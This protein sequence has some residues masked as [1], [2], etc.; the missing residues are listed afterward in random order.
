MP[1]RNRDLLTPHVSRRMPIQFVASQQSQLGKHSAKLSVRRTPKGINLLRSLERTVRKRA[2]QLINTSR[3]YSV[4]QHS[5]VPRETQPKDSNEESC[6]LEAVRLSRSGKEEE[7][8]KKWDARMRSVYVYSA[9]LYTRGARYPC[10]CRHYGLLPRENSGMQT[11]YSRVLN[12]L[13]NRA[14]AIY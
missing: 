10:R 12:R 13:L 9:P 5:E 7:T 6:V 14:G 8:G 3:R 2:N 1:F 11:R 4:F